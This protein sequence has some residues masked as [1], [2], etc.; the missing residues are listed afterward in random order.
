MFDLFKVK[1][2]KNSVIIFVESSLEESL[3]TK[4]RAFVA[5]ITGQ[6]VRFICNTL[7]TPI[8]FGK[9]VLIGAGKGGV[10]KS[11]LT[12]QLAHRFASDGISVGIVDAD[13]YQPSIPI[14]LGVTE[15]QEIYASEDS[16]IIPVKIGNIFL[17]SLGLWLSGANTV[18]WTAAMGIE[19]LRQFFHQ[20]D[21]SKCDVILIDMPSGTSEINLFIM[22]SIVSAIC[23]FDYNWSSSCARRC[24]EVCTNG[25]RVGY[26]N[27]WICA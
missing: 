14:M 2:H 16:K 13:M 23:Y 17:L 4:V 18:V 21:W 5:N 15:R 25:G 10:G 26:T 12:T 9:V 8:S 19:L 1:Q 3:Q 20:S 27:C 22:Q 7:Y 6:T 11:T 24:A